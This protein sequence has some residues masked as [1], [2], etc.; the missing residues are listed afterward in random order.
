M[1]C[2][3]CKTENKE[4]AVYCHH[5][6]A[7][8]SVERS[9]EY[10][11]VFKA[12]VLG[13]VG[14]ALFYSLFL[15]E[16][17]SVMVQQWFKGSVSEFITGLSLWSLFLVV[18][19]LIRYRFEA[20]HYKKF[21]KREMSRLLDS[22]IYVRDIDS[23]LNQISDQL[24]AQNLRH[25]HHSLIFRRVRRIFYNVRAIP[26][27]EEINTILD[28]Q[29]QIDQN[30]LDNGYTLINVF[31]WAIP[32]LGFIGTVYGIGQAIGDFSNFIR[33]VDS[34]ELGS[35][36]RSA[37]GGVTDGLSVA[38]NTTFL[39]L[40]FVIPIM[41]L[42]SFLR[43]AEEDLLLRIEEYCLEEVLPNIHI[44]P[45]NEEVQEAFD[46][47][48]HQLTLLSKNWLKHFEPLM[49]TLNENATT[50]R[51]QIQGLQPFVKDLS[52]HVLNQGNGHVNNSSIKGNEAFKSTETAPGNTDAPNPAANQPPTQDASRN[53]ENFT[54]AG[55][56]AN[57]TEA[58]SRIFAPQKDRRTPLNKSFWTAKKES[59]P[60]QEDID[61]RAQAEHSEAMAKS[62]ATNHSSNSTTH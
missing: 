19:K 8:L 12:L 47:H 39:A 20:R 6:G 1:R 18:F 62:T 40:V 14:T 50:F 2:W 33:T 43:K 3:N 4:V 48:L 38:F 55:T 11:D 10:I 16:I 22:G 59:A 41:T 56:V 29:A 24:K 45:G 9:T 53:W 25:F 34:V 15:P 49:Q 28:Y 31:I 58:H 32:I 5:C 51:S 44:H 21:R 60:L 42:S 13:M 46:E 37:L 23:T 52:E 30:H 7:Y 26:K 61:L 27:K 36:M 54:H 57:P 35:H 17:N